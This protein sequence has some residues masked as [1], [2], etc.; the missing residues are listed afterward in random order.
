M[1]KR[2]NT[3]QFIEKAKEIHG[4]KYDYSLVDYKNIRTKIK[5]I[6][7]KHGEFEQTPGKH[8]MGRGCLS[9]G[10]L[11]RKHPI[12][13]SDFIK[14]S[15]EIHGNKYDYS[16]VDYKNMKSKIKIICPKHGIF[17]QTPIAHLNGSSCTKCY[18]INTKDFIEKAKEIHGNKY[19]YSLV[20]YIHSHTKI[21]IICKKHDIFEQTPHNHIINKTICPKCSYYKKTKNI[22]KFI[23]DANKTHNNKYDYSLVNYVNNKTKVEII[24]PEHKIFKQSPIDHIRGCG[25]PTCKSSKGELKIRNY[26]KKHKIS[27]EPQHSF[28]DCKNILQL[29]FDF[30]IP[31]KNICIEFDGIQHFQPVKYFGGEDEFK[32]TQ[33]RDK[34]KNKYC[35]DN[36]IKLLRIKY[37]ENITNKLT[38][39]IV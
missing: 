10:K 21:K 29:S 4:N 35:K 37:N 34:I 13:N 14:R 11:K 7:L 3:T 26:L 30:Y 24:C 5:V 25:C 39:N 18:L 27:F 9:C 38:I 28:D 20:N 32:L 8:L 16:L 22:T 19:D 31:E 33:L 17:T 2:M 23:D 12:T 1:C 6:C 15:R 36:N